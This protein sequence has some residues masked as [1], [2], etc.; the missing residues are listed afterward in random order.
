M[1]L[2]R[3]VMS[4]QVLIFFGI[5]V[6]D[7]SAHQGHIHQAPTNTAQSAPRPGTEEQKCMVIVRRTFLE[8]EMVIYPCFRPIRGVTPVSAHQSSLGMVCRGYTTIP[9]TKYLRMSICCPGWYSDQ[10]GRCTMKVDDRGRESK[11]PRLS[12]PVKEDKPKNLN[13]LPKYPASYD[14]HRYGPMMRT[15][16]P[17]DRWTPNNMAMRRIQRMMEQRLRLIEMIERKMKEREQ[18]ISTVPPV[19][20][21]PVGKL[22]PTV[23]KFITV[24]KSFIPARKG[25]S[26]SQQTKIS[27]VPIRQQTAQQVPR[28]PKPQQ[29]KPQLI[30]SQKKTFVQVPRQS[31]PQFSP[32][33][34]ST[35]V[36]LNMPN[37]FPQIPQRPPMEQRQM[38][39]IPRAP[40]RRFQMMPG[41]VPMNR[42]MSQHHSQ[43]PR[44]PPHPMSQL[45]QRMGQDRVFLPRVPVQMPPV[46]VQPGP[47]IGFPAPPPCFAAYLDV[48]QSCFKESGVEMPPDHGILNGDY[49]YRG[50]CQEKIAI[51]DCI[52]RSVHPCSTLQEHMLIRTTMVNTLS[53]IDRICRIDNIRGI[54]HRMTAGDDITP[55]PTQLPQDNIH[56]H[57]D[58]VHSHPH[59][60]PHDHSHDHPHDHEHLPLDTPLDTPLQ[61]NT[62]QVEPATE[63]STD[64]IQFLGPSDQIKPDPVIEDKQ[65]IATEIKKEIKPEIKQAI[66]EAKK[67]ESVMVE[68]TKMIENNVDRHGHAHPHIQHTHDD[69]THE[70]YLP[71]LIGTAIG[72]A[73][74]FLLL[75]AILCVCCR[76][77]IK[78]KIYVEK[79][80][81]KPKLFEGIYTIGVPPPVY[82]VNGIPPLS[83]EEVRGVKITGS[84]SSVRRHNDANDEVEYSSRRGVVSDI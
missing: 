53:E 10:Q 48:V 35:R 79:E 65:D 34:Q 46:Q 84:P 7:S 63:P 68:L 26:P 11:M 62:V 13:S 28:I 19:P 37:P 30:I 69:I 38:P 6:L 8:K 71:I 70:Y 80:P 45:L 27:Q 67:D 64:G 76:R 56:M 83:Y 12:A 36:H 75:L 39:Q 40:D 21:S 15:Q 74:I 14:N 22:F 55:P 41:N 54:E 25:M 9:S 77:R 16:P 31:T 5:L 66:N 81:E 50:V 47:N 52:K 33:R 1:E 82:E 58:V 32:V 4:V 72:V 29:Q 42:H 73:A 57:G 59:D 49:N 18:S 51:A 24:S 61:E 20:Q 23:R 17:A 43:F 78:K 60:H 3:A 44:I 2:A